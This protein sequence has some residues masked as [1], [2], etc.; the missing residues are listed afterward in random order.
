MVDSNG[1]GHWYWLLVSVG[2]F[3]VAC[4]APALE[5]ERVRDAHRAW[6]WGVG[7]AIIGWIAI[8]VGQFGW[9]ANLPLLIGWLMVAVR[10]TRAAAFCGAIAFL[11]ALLTLQLMFK[12]FAAGDDHTSVSTVSRLGPGFFLWLG[13][14]LVLPIGA[15]FLERRFRSAQTPTQ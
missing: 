11:L 5:F 8:L 7:L 14:M 3:A 12:S 10:R 4:A 13:S 2:F 1:R 6:Q 15:V 9:F